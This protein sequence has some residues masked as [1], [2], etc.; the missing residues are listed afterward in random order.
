MIDKRALIHKTIESIKTDL[1]HYREISDPKMQMYLYGKI[2]GK[3]DILVDTHIITLHQ[4]SL[5]HCVISKYI[6]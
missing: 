2:I 4:W 6:Y 1:R 5:L 3:L